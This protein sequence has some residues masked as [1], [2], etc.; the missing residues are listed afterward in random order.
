MATFIGTDSNDQA[1]T[2]V[3]VLTGFTGG[4]FAELTDAIGDTFYGGGGNDIIQAGSGNDTLNG[5]AGDDFLHGGTGVDT[6]DYST[7]TGQVNVYLYTYTYAIGVTSG[8][9]TLV[10]IENVTGGFGSDYLYGDYQVNVLIGGWGNDYLRGLQGGDT[11]EGGDGRDYILGDEGAD[12]I[13]GGNDGDIIDGGA[14]NDVINGNAGN[15]EL[16][17]G[18]GADQLYGGT[19][20]DILYVDRFDTVMDG[21]AGFDYLVVQDVTGL[22]IN[23]GSTIEWAHGH[24]GNDVLY[25]LGAQQ[26]IEL[27]GGDGNDTLVGAA[28]FGS[29]LLGDAG[30]D[31]LVSESF[32]DH[33]V[34]GAGA[35]TFVF[36]GFTSSV[37]NL[38]HV[39]DFEQGVD[40]IDVTALAN[41]AAYSG[42]VAVHSM[43]DLGIDESYASNGWHHVVYHRA[44]LWI[45]TGSASPL[46]ASDFLFA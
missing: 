17:G 45:Y 40:K 21:G 29:I 25:A 43:A 24:T 15:D 42:T 19:D 22:T 28:D 16:Y 35:D 38:D 39:Y 2:V 11:L 10:S 14:D 12:T 23:L 34:G 26:R 20:T 4:T 37:G 1:D 41:P 33:M 5:G 46:A 7:E 6:V 3:N 18:A 36:T 44:D 9:D 13:S 27:H 32:M 31:R 30:N 8:N